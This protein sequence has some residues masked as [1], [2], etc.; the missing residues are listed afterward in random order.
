MMLLYHLTIYAASASLFFQLNSNNNACLHSCPCAGSSAGYT[1][2]TSY[3]PQ[4]EGKGEKIIRV[5]PV[6][7]FTLTTW[8]KGAILAN[9]Y[10]TDNFHLA[11][12]F[13]PIDNYYLY[14]VDTE[15]RAICP[16]SQSARWSMMTR[17]GNRMREENET[18]T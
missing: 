17:R 4:T 5:S 12:N 10:L 6:N 14:C 16:T 1:V 8:R 2:R 18:T 13:Y 7:I 11:D 9:F 15:T 3:V